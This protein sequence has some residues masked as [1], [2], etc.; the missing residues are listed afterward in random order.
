M[1]QMSQLS[2]AGVRDS[3]LATW[4][5]QTRVDGV[6]VEVLALFTATTSALYASRR[7][8]TLLATGSHSATERLKGVDMVRHHHRI[9]PAIAL[10]LALAAAPA[11]AKF[12][13]NPPA[14]IQTHPSSRASTN[15]CSEVCSAGGYASVKQAAVTSA[16]GAALP[17]DPRPRSEVVSG[18][19]YGSASPAAASRSFTGP[20]SEVVSGSGYGNPSVRSTV[21]R[22]VAP[23]G[24]FHWGDAGIG[25]GGA[26]A[27]I[28]LAA[29]V[30]LG[31]TNTRR[32]ASRSSAQPTT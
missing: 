14:G 9:A 22:V 6:P 13:L 27:L 10:T 15:L 18:G 21:V 4:I 24:G 19:G 12:E 23:S 28:M 26:F 32:R 8:L 2:T 7:A 17:H 29:G 30:V 5:A 11:S 1:I 25:A 16:T 3:G 31:T 20:R